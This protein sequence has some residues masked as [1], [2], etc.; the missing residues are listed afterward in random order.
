MYRHLS[1]PTGEFQK[2]MNLDSVGM[3]I[4]EEEDDY[5]NDQEIPEPEESAIRELLGGRDRIDISSLMQEFSDKKI[6]YLSEYSEKKTEYLPAPSPNRDPM[7]TNEMEEIKMEPASPPPQMDYHG[8][9]GNYSVPPVP[10]HLVPLHLPAPV[11]TPLETVQAEDK[12]RNVFMRTASQDS[13][14]R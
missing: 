1:P 5:Y 10:P 11:T 12:P 14:T 4:K 6:E 2:M 7:I 13:I 3:V 8:H 9:H